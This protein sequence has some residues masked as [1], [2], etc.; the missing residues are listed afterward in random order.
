MSEPL[1][2][3]LNKVARGTGIAIVGMTAGLLF[4]FIAKLVIA[5]HGMEANYGMFSLAMAV[6]NL[7]MLLACLGLHQGA[8][9]YIAFTRARGDT[10]T[11]RKVISVSIWSTSVASILISIAVFLGADI[12]ALSVFHNS[13]LAQF[14]RI[15]AAGIPFFTLLYIVAAIF[16]GFDRV[17]PQVYFQ[18]LTLN[19]LFVI[20]LLLAVVA[21]LP[22][23]SVFYA[24]LLA[25]VISFIGIV[26]YT[27]KRLSLPVIPTGEEADKDIIK[28]LF[29]FSVPLLGA[30]LLGTAELW[31]DTL[32]LGYFKPSEV[33][34]LYSAAYPLAQSISLP[35]FALI[36]I[37]TPIV[38]GLYS[39]NLMA[40]LKRSYTVL[41]KW[42]VFITIP[43]FLVL[44]L[45]PEYVL[46]LLFGKTYI[47]AAPA[48]SILS[49]GF[50]VS[51]LLG[52]SVATLIALGKSRFIMWAALV[53][54][55]VNV[56]LSIV[57]IPSLSI[58]GAA[59]ASAVSLS[60]FAIIRAV[61]LYTLC[62]A[63][64]LSRNL[65]KPLV[66]SVVLA[67]LFQLIFGNLIFVMWYMLPLLFILY[68]AI[69]GIATVLSRS[70]D[71]EDIVMLLEVEKRIGINAEPIKKILRRFL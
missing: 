47:G 29:I 68:Y 13:Q 50:I 10:A 11:V 38:T 33:V 18:Y 22:F 37:Y 14:L 12:I 9:R 55:A 56:I 17:A 52:P 8:T 26:V 31:I 4:G 28:H 71:K 60:L 64:P 43:I 39:R 62:R 59:V 16:R 61:R 46:R 63:Q 34:G 69:Y 20:F 48:L 1:D 51:T 42:L 54:V 27:I 6:L 5:K 53:S 57:L 21:D 45:Y 2:N 25:L 24:Y 66:V 23:V 35:L 36:L 7:A 41:T 15:F 32:I 30:A 65:L 44:C 67:L 49:V 70:F 3:S 58:V 40:D 19:I